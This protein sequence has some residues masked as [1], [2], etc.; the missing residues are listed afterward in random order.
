[1]SILM[2]N[3]KTGQAQRSMRGHRK[4]ILPLSRN[5]VPVVRRPYVITRDEEPSK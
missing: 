3:S 2:F 4:M 5:P 1:M